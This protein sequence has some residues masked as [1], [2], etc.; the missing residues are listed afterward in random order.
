MFF[1]QI[2]IA[3]LSLKRNPLLSALLIGAIA[4]GI[5]VS[6]AFVT[7]YHIAAGNPIPAKSDRLFLVEVDS[8]DPNTPFRASR[9]DEP[10]YLL[11]YRD[12][13]ALGQSTIPTLQSALFRTS[14]IVHPEG[15]AERPYRELVRM[16]SGDFFPMFDVPFTYGS[17]WSSSADAGPEPV[18]VIDGETNR[19]LFGG[20]NSVGRT[21][22]IEDQPFTVTGVLAEWRPT[23]KFYDIFSG[24]Y[25]EADAIY[26]PF[27]YFRELEVFTS[28]NIWSWKDGEGNTFEDRLASEMVWIQMWVELE[29]A[30]QKAEYMAFLDAYVLEQK[31][32]GRFQRPLNNRLL[33]VMQWLENAEVVPDDTKGM[34]VIS[35]LFLAV[36]A[37]NLI[38]ILLGKFLAR[39]PEVGVRRALGA[40]R[41]AVFFQHLV[42]CELVGVIGGVLGIGLSILVLGQLNR[43]NPG[44]LQYQLDGYMIAAGLGLSVVAGLIAGIYPA[45]R[46]CRVAPATHLKLQ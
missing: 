14:L 10:P 34:L 44:T 35:L 22:L 19:R 12:T 37:V 2:K 15:E 20:E 30:D 25:G 40:S 26:M 13:T 1:Y 32:L 6:T 28:G 39:A 11:T 17:G 3:F 46:I 38:G 5:A 23:P 42:E 43:M 21:L 24:I 36:C 27:E 31:K 4:L 8:W 41:A 29:D 16:C 45:W 7:A 18:I 9:P 33:D